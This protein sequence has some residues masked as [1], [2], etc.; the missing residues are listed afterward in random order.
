[1]HP[2][3]EDRMRQKL[4]EIKGPYPCVKM[5]SENPGV[6]TKCPHW[7]KITNP[8]AI[9]RTLATDNTEKHIEIQDEEEVVPFQITRPAPP[10]GYSYGAK[11]GIFAD[12]TLED[13][14]GKKTKKSVMILPYTLS[15]VS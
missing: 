1:M 13:D 4:R 7:G 2:Y 8:L 14:E 12:K 11:G 3:D 10:R 6:C 9:C 5:D 15:A